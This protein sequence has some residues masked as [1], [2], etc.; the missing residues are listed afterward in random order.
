MQRADQ[1]CRGVPLQENPLLGNCYERE[2]P[3]K[4]KKNIELT[5]CCQKTGPKPEKLG[6]LGEEGD[7]VKLTGC[8]VAKGLLVCR[9][10]MG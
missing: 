1:W 2:E 8:K 10:L 4:E 3:I 5:E 7:V 9:S 6:H